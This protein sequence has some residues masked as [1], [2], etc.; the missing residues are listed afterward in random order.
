MIRSPFDKFMPIPEGDVKELDIILR[1]I[2][3]DEFER[4]RFHRFEYRR[5]INHIRFPVFIDTVTQYIC[6]PFQGRAE[7]VQLWI[8]RILPVTKER[9]K[10]TL[11]Q[12]IQPMRTF[13]HLL[14]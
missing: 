14:T 11:D 4:L 5:I 12:L 9:I 3:T 8:I 10:N 13:Y 2:D 7:L 6:L 1:N